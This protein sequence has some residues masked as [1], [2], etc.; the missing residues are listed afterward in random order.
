MNVDSRT[1]RQ[2]EVETGS[3]AAR[4]TARPGVTLPRP[5]LVRGNGRRSLTM[6]G[7]LLRIPLVW[8]LAGAN[9]ALVIF[10]VTAVLMASRIDQT[11]PILAVTLLASFGVNIALVHVA[12]QPIGDLE[13]TATRVWRG[14]LE[15]RVTPSPMADRDM[16][17]VGSTFNLLL[18][19]LTADRARMRLLAAQVISAQDAERARIARELHD[20]TAQ[21]LA[22]AILQLSAAHRQAADDP[23][24]SARLEELRELVG[25]ALEEV[26]S[27]SHTI[28]PRVLDD[29]GLPAALEWLA[30]TTRESGGVEIVVEA[31][32]DGD[33]VPPAVASVL[34]RVA[35]ESVRNAS[36][37]SEAK[38][39]R[40][41]LDV[42]PERATLIVS[43]D[44][45]GFDVGEAEARRPGMGLF[46][47]RERVALVNGSIDIH[48]V[49]G[50]G[51]RITAAVP[52]GVS[53]VRSA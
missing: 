18:D 8:K 7:R 51:T 31:G 29:L 1:E 45:R 12:L 14:D 30:R 46:S 27:L 33:A 44:G 5:Q 15:A 25:A 40:L 11:I 10:A 35:Q 38:T 16:E 52:L 39:I 41:V 24:L 34:Y 9:A 36:Q 49:P 43:D 48:S 53:A 13:R 50:L 21:T 32:P 28:H 20:S 17:R 47:I 37:H 23:A 6:G 42:T 19:G 26:R 22:A 2:S 4:E 3:G